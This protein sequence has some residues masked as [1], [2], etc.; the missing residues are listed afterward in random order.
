MAIKILTKNAVDNTNIDGARQ[1]HFNAGMRSGIVK[2]AFNEGNM[3][4]SSSNVLAL[5]TCELRI[6]GHRIVIDEIETFTMGS[7]PTVETNYSLIAEISVDNSSVPSFRMFIQNSNTELIKQNLF[8][9]STGSGVY[10]IEIGTFIL[11]TAGTIVGVRRTADLIT[12]E[13]PK[14]LTTFWTND[15]LNEELSTITIYIPRDYDMLMVICKDNNDVH[16]SHTLPRLNGGVCINNYEFLYQSPYG[17]VKY[18]RWISQFDFND[19][20]QLII[21]ECYK[22]TYSVSR[23][24]GSIANETDNTKLVP[25]KIVGIKL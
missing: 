22:D 8:S 21:S 6:S 24:N 1:S 5:D 23:G 13:T 9:N 20:V 4:A 15:T 16:T 14:Q 3:F 18:Q 2:G 17:V 10:Q 11:T 25:I 12:G 7:I 19:N